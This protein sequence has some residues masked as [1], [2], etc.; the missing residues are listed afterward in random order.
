MELNVSDHI[1]LILTSILN[2]L[3]KLENW[4][5]LAE[6]LSTSHPVYLRERDKMRKFIQRRKKYYRNLMQVDRQDVNQ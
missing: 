2:D 1:N 3:T 5:Y 6:S 4:E